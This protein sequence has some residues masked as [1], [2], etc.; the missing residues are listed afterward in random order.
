MTALDYSRL[1]YQVLRIARANLGYGDNGTNSGR[2]IEAMGGKQGADWCALFAGYCYRRAHEELGLPHP[3]WVY[4]RGSSYQTGA[5]A[6]VKALGRVG[7]LFS[8]GGARQPLPGDLVAWSR[9]RIP[10]DWRGHVGIVTEG[11]KYI[12]GNEGR[13]GKVHERFISDCKLPLW[14]FAS[15]EP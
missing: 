13:S 3:D 1:R 15:I 12:A 6:L 7:A 11:G 8:P 9:T 2:F 14:R 5:K 4:R 10:G